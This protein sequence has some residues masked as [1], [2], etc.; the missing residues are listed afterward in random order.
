MSWND[1]RL[2]PIAHMGILTNG[3]G[4]PSVDGHIQGTFQAASSS[5]SHLF[6]GVVP[7]EISG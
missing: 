5:H 4:S 7:A 3:R 6:S 1:G 2:I